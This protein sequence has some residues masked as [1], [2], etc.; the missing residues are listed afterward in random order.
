MV[1]SQDTFIAVAAVSRR[2]VHVH[3]AAM[4]VRYLRPVL[5]RRYL[6]RLG[7]NGIVCGG[8]GLC[9]ICGGKEYPAEYDICGR[10]ERHC[11]GIVP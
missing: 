11:K 6:E 7:E 3:L 2:A 10:N 8:N 4:A 5:G 9:E 1:E